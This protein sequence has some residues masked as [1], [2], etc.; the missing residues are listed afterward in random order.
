MDNDD[1]DLNG[2]L[3]MHNR[4]ILVASR[5][6][7]YGYIGDYY[8]VASKRAAFYYCALS[9]VTAFA[10]TKTFMR[11]I[12][13]KFP[14]L[15]SEMLA[16]SFSRYVKEIRK[17]CGKKRSDVIKKLNSKKMYSQINLDSIAE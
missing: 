1:L 15:A 4:G 13:D 16:E 12:F 2:T 6:T 17:G 5:K 8:A 7:G 11:L 10:L 9:R 3:D 14:G